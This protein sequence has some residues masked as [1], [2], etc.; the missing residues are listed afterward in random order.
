MSARRDGFVT[1]S[2]R[3]HWQTYEVTETF[4][5]NQVSSGSLLCVDDIGVR[6]DSESQQSALLELLNLRHG[7]PTV[8]TG[9]HDAKQ[10]S[11]I[12][13]ARIASR[14]ASGTVI[15]LTGPDRRLKQC[16]P[17]RIDLGKN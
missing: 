10:L 1:M 14:L 12:F 13:D 11:Q 2:S 3:H 8:I 7:L 4:L 9:N 16:E 15:H 6:G 17:V 5:L